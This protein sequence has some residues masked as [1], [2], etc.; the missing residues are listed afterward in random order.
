M[1]GSPSSNSS[2]D[3]SFALRLNCHPLA[4]RE[5]KSVKSPPSAPTCKMISC[6]LMIIGDEIYNGLAI[7]FS[8]DRFGNIF[9][10]LFL[11]QFGLAVAVEH[12]RA[13]IPDSR[14]LAMPKSTILTTTGRRG[15]PFTAFRAGS[16]ARPVSADGA[17]A[18]PA[19]AFWAP[20][21]G[22]PTACAGGTPA[23]QRHPL[24]RSE[25]C[26]RV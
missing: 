15:G 23:L 21:R 13:G 17:G 26:Y 8:L 9:W 4:V 12:R 2:G 10:P 25:R 14:S 22:A 6:I 5:P 16:C 24:D 11:A 19:P 3:E 1:A 20:T 7:V 18:W